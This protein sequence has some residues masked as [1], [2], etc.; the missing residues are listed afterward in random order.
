MIALSTVLV[1]AQSN[2]TAC[3][4]AMINER[5]AWPNTTAEQAALNIGFF[6]PFC[7][8]E[9]GAAQYYLRAITLFPQYT[10]NSRPG[11]FTDEQKLTITCQ[12]KTAAVICD[13]FP[14]PNYWLEL[15]AP[16]T[17]NE[18]ECLQNQQSTT[19]GS[20][21]YR[22]CVQTDGNFVVYKGTIEVANAV[23]S[24][25]TDK[26]EPTSTGTV[27]DLM[28]KLLLKRERVK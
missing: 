12:A 18:G 23:W 15:I 19:T 10:I 25:G 1:E 28:F 4:N 21:L 11:R 20:P 2:Q 8:S 7:G 22:A 26:K 14:M 24:S 3:M 17:L 9:K 27:S 16:V 5:L 13:P 6:V